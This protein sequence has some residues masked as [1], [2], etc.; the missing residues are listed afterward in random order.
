[1]LA[2]RAGEDASSSLAAA[3]PHASTTNTAHATWVSGLR[4]ISI[5]SVAPC[6]RPRGGGH[7]NRPSSFPV[8]SD[9]S[10]KK[11]CS[12]QEVPLAARNLGDPQARGGAVGAQALGPAGPYAVIVQLGQ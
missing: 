2:A 4:R 6:L 3:P 7:A 12:E 11:T 1:M 5:S 9:Y 10:C 8:V